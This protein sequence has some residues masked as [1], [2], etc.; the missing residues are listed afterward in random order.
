MCGLNNAVVKEQQKGRGLNQSVAK[1]TAEPNR[2]NQRGQRGLPASRHAKLGSLYRG[3]PTWAHAAPA[4]GG[5]DL[6]QQG[7]P[8]TS[9]DREKRARPVDPPEC[10]DRPGRAKGTARAMRS[11]PL[12]LGRV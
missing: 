4:L 6:S 7:P 10:R 1:T 12:G 9:R 11:G 2:L 3:C 5:A 8:R